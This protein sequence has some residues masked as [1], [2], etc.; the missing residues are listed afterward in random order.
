[1]RILFHC[2]GGAQIGVGH[3]VRSVALAEEAIASGHDVVFVG[4]YDGSFVLDLLETTGA[5]VQRVAHGIDHSQELLKAVD[6][7]RPE[8]VHLDTYDD[9]ELPA[10]AERHPLLSNVEDAGFGRR[11]ADVVIDPNFGSETEPRDTGPRDTEQPLLL[12]RGSRYSPLRARVTA[13]RGAWQLRDEASRVLV[14]MGGTDPHGLTPRALEVLARTGLPFHVTAIVRP[15]AR[16]A[17]EAV[18]PGNLK[19]DLVEPVEDL[20][21]LA[22][23]QD[24]VVSAA[25]TSVWELCCLGVPMGLVCAADNQRAGYERV[26]AAEAAIGL[27]ATLQ[28]EEAVAAASKLKEALEVPATRSALSSQASRLVDGLGAWRVVRAWEQLVESEPRTPSGVGL[29]VRPATLDDAQTLLRWRNDPQTRASSRH[30]GEI[31]LQEHISW[32][33][34]SLRSD[35]RRLSVASDEVGDVGTVRWDLLEPGVWEVS[36]TVAPER[37]GEGMALNLL[38]AGEGALCAGVDD[39]VAVE[40]EVHGENTPS[41][42]LFAAAGYVPDRPADEEGFLRFRKPLT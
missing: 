32:L 39:M 38:S 13:R 27:G 41:R 15:E 12:L 14:V 8:V 20:P 34:A 31:S 19:V 21:G 33:E 28:G 22:V 10:A 6:E 9:V 37:R 5:E 3:V 36:I 42:R 30:H 2:N 35:R 24:L 16:A 29:R 7:V 17:A 40:A 26:I 11:R 18:E 4:E 23:S 25:G 1:M